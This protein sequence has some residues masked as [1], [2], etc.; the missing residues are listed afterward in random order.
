MFVVDGV[1]FESI[2]D[3]NPADIESIEVLKDAASAAIYGSRSANGVILISTKQGEK[4]R[5]R[6]DIRYLKSFSTLTRKM[7][8]ATGAK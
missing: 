7:P 6:L 4:S 3:I 8:K 1:P 2:D 5:P